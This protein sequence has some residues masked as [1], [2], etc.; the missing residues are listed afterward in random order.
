MNSGP[1]FSDRVQVTM[2]RMAWRSMRASLLPLLDSLGCTAKA[3]QPA[4]ENGF[5]VDPDGGNVSAKRKGRVVAIGASGRALARL[6]AMSLLGEFLARLSAE[7]H[8][9]TVLDVTMDA[10]VDAPPVLRDV[11]QRA[12]AGSLRLTRKAIRPRDVVRIMSVR[13]HDGE[14]TGTVYLGSRQAEVQM[15]VYDKQAE[16]LFHG[17]ERG[18]GVRYEVTVKNGLP[19]LR[20]VY[21]PASL[22]WHHA[23]GVLQRPQ[24]VPE[25][26]PRALGMD[27]E[28]LPV[29][30]P[31]ELLRAKL[32]W[33]PDVRRVVE[34]ADQLPGGRQ[35]LLKELGYAFPRSLASEGEAERPA[36]ASPRPPS[37]PE[38]A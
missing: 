9:V 4:E 25:W 34:L 13:E 8:R 31:L 16:R 36:A 21:E 11:Y 26:E 35:M 10:E 28:A 37:V 12:T 30:E 6:R 20:D 3:D 14:E 32:L 19:T 24:G 38:L 17:V 15:R 23:Q 33:S 1:V 22:F 18:P 5:W 7:P 27:L 29:R 2:D